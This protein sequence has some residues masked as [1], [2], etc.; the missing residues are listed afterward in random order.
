VIRGLS[1]T[2]DDQ[3]RFADV[4]CAVAADTVGEK[5]LVKYIRRTDN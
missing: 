3:R 2:V 1:R 5:A 4:G